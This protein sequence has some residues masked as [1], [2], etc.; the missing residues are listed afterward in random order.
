MNI[1]IL[2]YP[3][4][5]VKNRVMIKFDTEDDL[6]KDAYLIYQ[7]KTDTINYFN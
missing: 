3:S 5:D 4:L 7:Y 6:E 2:W 1:M